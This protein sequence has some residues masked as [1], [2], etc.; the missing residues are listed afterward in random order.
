MLD[1]EELGRLIE[2]LTSRPEYAMGTRRFAEA[3]DDDDAA[4][5]AEALQRQLE[6]GLRAREE[7]TRRK[8]LPI[9]CARDAT[10]DAARSS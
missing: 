1:E 9:A 6:P 5:I 4:E 2:R 7:A 3:I 10:G 8:R